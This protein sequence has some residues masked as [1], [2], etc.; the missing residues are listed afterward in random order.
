MFSSAFQLISYILNFLAF[1]FLEHFYTYNMIIWFF[2]PIID[3]F[4]VAVSCYPLSQYPAMWID[5]YD[6]C[7]HWQN[8]LLLNHVHDTYLVVISFYVDF[9]GKIVFFLFYW[10]WYSDYIVAIKYQA[11]FFRKLRARKGRRN[12]FPSTGLDI[13]DYL[14]LS[15]LLW[16]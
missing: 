15:I 3:N 9:Y 6:C 12:F 4:V 7:C 14:N 8:N 1:K 2:M 10:W 16:I 5:N 11:V 13:L